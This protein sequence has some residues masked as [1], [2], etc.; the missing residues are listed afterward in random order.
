MIEHKNPPPGSPLAK[1]L[2]SPKNFTIKSETPKL[3]KKILT[4]KYIKI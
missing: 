2:S 3:F 4:E 1:L